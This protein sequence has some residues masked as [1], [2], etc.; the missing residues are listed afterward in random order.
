[1]GVSFACRCES[2]I[3]RSSFACVVLCRCAVSCACPLSWCVLHCSA[4]CVCSAGVF[5]DTKSFGVP[6]DLGDVSKR[7]GTNIDYFQ[8]NYAILVAITLLYVCYHQQ[9]VFWALALCGGVGYWLF[10]VREK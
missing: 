7:L 2:L 5:F 1:M 6:K 9:S 4:L 8:A 3:A 10:N